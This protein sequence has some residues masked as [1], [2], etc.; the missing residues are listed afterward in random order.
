MNTVRLTWRR[1]LLNRNPSTLIVLAL[2]VSMAFV[3]ACQPIMVPLESAE[4]SPAAQEGVEAGERSYYYHN[5]ERVELGINATRSFV[6][7]DA[8]AE[9]EEISLSFESNDA[10]ILQYQEFAAPGGLTLTQEIPTQQWAIID[11]DE[12]EGTAFES[13]SFARDATVT[14]NLL[15][16]APFYVIAN[17]EEVGISHL[18]YVKLKGAEDLGQLQELAQELNVDILGNNRFMP[19]WY[20]L[21]STTESSGNALEAANAFFESG[22]FEAA[23]PDFLVDYR[24]FQVVNDTHFGSQWGLL[25][26]GQHG[27]TVGMDINI[28]DAWTLSTGDSDI[29][30]A[31][32]D[33]GV[34]LNHPDMPNISP[35]SFD[36]VNGTSPSQVRGNHGTACAGIVG[37]ARNNS[38][39]VAGVAPDITLMSVSH[40]LVTGVNASQQLANGINWAWENGADVISNSWGHTLLASP[41]MDDAIESALNQGRGGA[42][43]VVVFATGNSNASSVGYPANS[44]PDILAV[45]AMSPCGER[46]NPFSCDGEN[47]GSQF[48]DEVDVVAPGVLIPTTDIQGQPGYDTDDYTLTFNGTSSATPHVAGIAS[49]ILSINPQL[50]RQQVVDIIE[51]TAQKVS[52][53][54]YQNV[55]GRNNGGWNDEMGYGLVDAF[56]A[57]LEATDDSCDTLADDFD[58]ALDV[59]QWSMVENGVVNTN[60]SDTNSLFFTGGARAG[61]TRFATTRGMDVSGGG[62]ILFQLIFGNSANGGENADA[63]EDVVLEFSTDGGS[64][65]SLL[66]QY[67]TEDFTE[68]TS[69]SESIP[70]PAQSSSTLFRWRQVRHSGR[71]F[72]QWGLDNV[73]ITCPASETFQ[74]PLRPNQFDTSLRIWSSV[75]N[76]NQFCQEEGFEKMAAGLIGCGEDESSY[77]EFREENWLSR[78]SGSKNQCY[79]I[80]HS[81][82]CE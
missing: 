39:G 51:Q 75:T 31:V 56:A 81:I 65:W 33:H 15:Y 80:F 20:T 38:I 40:T 32:V 66:E 73:L 17:G 3:V 64:S 5:G 49:L 36:T 58:A 7:F 22:L 70:A 18:F 41:L 63:G 67:D 27:G 78:P 24:P 4:F 35:L 53:Y 30:V 46:K 16:Q 26:T 37:A 42:G 9:Q 50:T 2:F 52:G 21:A 29:V 6:L 82:S 12:L 55:V 47:W 74:S 59:S 44:N 60:F 48:G 1:R 68:W 69:I 54:N 8:Q 61:N 45:G 77:V 62:T 11:S 19:L 28:E 43:T 57:A 76:G 13:S 25:N 10:Q 34:E 23:E 71:N 14:D 72:D 79:D